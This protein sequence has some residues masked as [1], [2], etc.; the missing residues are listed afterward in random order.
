[1][2]AGKLVCM[3]GHIQARIQAYM[4]VGKLVHIPEP[5]EGKPERILA[6]K[7]EGMVEGK[8]ERKQEP[9][10]DSIPVCRPEDIL[11]G[12]TLGMLAVQ[13]QADMVDHNIQMNCSRDCLNIPSIEVLSY[14]V[15][16]TRR[17]ILVFSL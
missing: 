9:V 8:P 17:L 14:T 5:V 7:P 12:M 11:V 13:L 3:A 6:Y 4:A 15:E 1:M 2:E 10:A 16:A